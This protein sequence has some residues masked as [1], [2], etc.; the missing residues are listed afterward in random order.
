MLTR[1]PGKCSPLPVELRKDP[2]TRS[3]VITGDDPVDAPRSEWPCPFCSDA[4]N[5]VQVIAATPANP[6]TPWSARAVVHPTPLY[7]IEG[8]P[9]RRGD[10]I[11]DRMHSVGAHEVLIENPRHDR[12]LWNAGDE[13]IGHFLRLAAE[14]ILDL[15]RDPRVKYVSL[16]KDYGKNAGQGFSHPSSEITATMFVPR[17][18]LYEL[19]AG[20]EYFVAKERCVFCDIIQQEERQAQRVVEARGDYIA[21][22]PYAPRVPYETWI[23]PR[24]HESSFERTGLNKPGLRTNLAALLRRT[25]QRVRSITEDF[26]LVLHTAPS[27]L[28]PS[29]NLGYWKTIDEDYHW[30]IEILP[31]IPSKARPYTFKE[32]YYSPVSSE[33]AV[34]QLREAKIE[35]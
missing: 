32:V 2:I 35:G 24:N 13:E 15:K 33:T 21:M 9:G 34:K 31:I 20:R 11:Y 6:G 14:R 29:K 27:T 28:H 30:H 16:F 12:H 23:L 4:A 25:L 5:S 26:H 17:R 1:A 22:C 8:D 7:R 18:V 3:W 10:G 19:R